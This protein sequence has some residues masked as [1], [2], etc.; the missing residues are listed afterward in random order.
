MSYT[1]KQLKRDK[2]GIIIPQYWNE[3]TKEFEP[4]QG[5]GGAY[6]MQASI[7][8]A[9][10]PFEGTGDLTKEFASEMIGLVIS[11][12]SE[13]G[14]VGAA[15]LTF[16]IHGQTRT[17]KA[18]EVWNSKF[19]P[20]KEVIIKSTVPWRAEALQTTGLFAATPVDTTAPDNVTN[21]TASNVT[22][23]S[24]TL[25]WTASASNDCVGYD[26]YRG[27][28]QIGSVAGAT[29]NVTGLTQNTQYT[30]TVKAKD[31]AGNI[32]SGTA[33]TVTTAES[34]DATPPVITASPAGGTYAA[35]Q[36]VTLTT[37][38]QATIYYTLDGSTPTTSSAVYLAPIAINVTTT[39]K[40]FGRDVA[41]NISN[42]QA[43]EYTINI[44]DV[45]LPIVTA[46]PSGGTYPTAQ[47]VK[48]AANEQATI[49]YTTDG[50][51]PSINSPV[52]S[53]PINVAASMTIRFFG[54]DTAGN[55]SSV[56][57]AVYTIGS[58]PGYVN[59]SSLLLYQDNPALNQTIAN[60]DDFFMG[61]AHFT[62]FAT[63]KP[64]KGASNAAVNLFSKI[65]P[66]DAQLVFGYNHL[67]KF[68]LN[69]KGKTNGA[70]EFPQLLSEEKSD[71]VFYHVVAVRDAAS[72]HLYVDNVL[73]KSYQFTKGE[74]IIDSTAP[75]VFGSTN[76][77]AIIK[78]MGYY[79]R[80][81]TT[82]ELTQNYNT[83]K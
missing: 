51:A 22:A 59:D 34:S 38:E 35:A 66:N 69:I 23:T 41:G 13:P 78:N 61:T 82:A 31:A 2:K 16:T 1:E 63:V 26:V 79:T 36:T 37:N 46:S 6:R 40:Y 11:N 28:T 27:T 32:A 65:A 21:L 42:I 15:S 71:D 24:L 4:L 62:A 5:S 54:K 44:P 43:Q 25:S 81:L 19:K 10:E 75:L 56:Q 29:Y 67:N 57:S 73:A 80:A 77:Q 45:T 3:E 64:I 7:E 30:F 8:T 49:Y 70:V 74:F 55:V 52:Y 53:A 76:N 33:V 9:A 60:K 18:G 50:S 14:K 48:L 68:A 12:D 20:F 58:V 72:L 47:S 17:V 83:L 39:L